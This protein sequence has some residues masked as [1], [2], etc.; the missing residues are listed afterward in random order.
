MLIA[1]PFRD[2]SMTAT[3]PQKTSPT[4]RQARTAEIRERLLDAAEAIYAE[5]GPSGLTARAVTAR[6]G[7]TT[8]AIY[9]YF[10]NL[11]AV[12]EAMYERAVEGVESILEQVPTTASASQSNAVVNESL[13][14]TAR[15]YRAY[16]LAHPGRLRLLRTAAADTPMAT[17]GVEL[18]ERLFEVVAAIGAANS[19]EDHAVFLGRL[20]ATL[21]AVHG[22]IQAELDGFMSA[23]FGPDQLFDELIH[24][25]LI[26][27]KELPPVSYPDR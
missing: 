4:P 13:I 23:E 24:R 9:R 7:Q 18:R 12:I 16:C 8:Q 11:D 6:A 1:H 20:R 5:D 27:T 2:F 15:A 26:E 3:S 19:K 21:A 22:F 17:S 10:E 25:Y 14:R